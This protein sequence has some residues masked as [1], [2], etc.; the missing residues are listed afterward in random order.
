MANTLYKGDLAEVSFGKE[1]G[2]RIDG[3]TSQ[4]NWVHTS[5]SGNTSLLTLGADEYWTA[6]GP[7]LKLPDNIL[8][9][10]TLR[11]EGGDAY[12]A[13]DFATTKRTYY[14]TAS[15]TGAG[16]ITV[17]PALLTA[18][19]T[20]TKDDDNLVIDFYRCPTFESTM[21]T[22]NQQVKTD[23]FIGLLNE[24]AIPE[25]EIDVRQQHIVGLGR[26]VNILTS[27]RETL[28]GGSMQLNA[29][30]LR[31]MKYALGGHSAKSQ[32]EFA[33]SSAAGTAIGGFPLNIA[34]GS[35]TATL[36]AQGYGVS[37]NT[38][39]SITATNSSALTM[40]GNSLTGNFLLGGMVT[41][42]TSTDITFDTA[43][44]TTFENALTTGGIFKVL[45]ATGAVLYGS[46][47]SA[48]GAVLS[49]C[50]DIDSGALARAQTED[51]AVYLL[52]SVT[53]NISAGDIRIKVGSA[54]A[55]K[56]TAGTS[57][58]QII[59]KDKH[60]IPGQDAA[61]TDRQIFKNELRRVIAIGT[62]NGN[63]ADYIYVE[64][65]LTFDHT[66]TSCGVERL[67]Y[68]GTSNQRG[69]P[70]IDATSKELQFG[71]THTLFGHNVLPSFTV[72]QS[73][74]QKDADVDSKQLL[75]LY[76][77]C[78][79]TEATIDADSE[80]EVKLNLSYEAARHY[81][82][83]TNTMKPH[84]MFDNTAESA[85][86][87]KISGIAVD[88]EKPYL[89]QDVN[90]EVFGRP[91]LRG[92]QFSLSVTNNLES[93]WFIRGYEGTTVDND[94]IQHGATQLPLE[95]TEGKR[96]YSFS[97][98]VM[99]EDERLWD[100]LR[101]RKHH[102]NTNDI[103]ITMTKVGSNATRETATITLED[104]TITK[105]EHQVPSDKSPVMADVE[106][107]VR[108]M[109]VSENS[110]YFIL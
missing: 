33:Y 35:V 110:P 102:K 52:G 14:I 85:V 3:K 40:T 34:T 23:Q 39:T 5:V 50:A 87:R 77:G 10:C 42:D 32:G 59:D 64:E 75:R 46:Y 36:A 61:E 79:A 99:V 58:V 51:K 15:D 53:A 1:T 101:T 45:S 47:G 2:L 86:N 90:V 25:P 80:G 65:P 108:H 63:D 98:Q 84:R 37:D 18:S 72:E 62:S 107:V 69:S 6:T 83:T 28:S 95:I 96:E 68:T 11:I 41:A 27:G 94:Q 49:S 82:A 21:T 29:H 57:Y 91:V 26:D 103:T 104:Y 66:S 44:A 19:G 106:I 17:Q 70:H 8:I 4:A 20:A 24:F 88:G 100:E 67:Q 81:T 76:S 38:D 48:S 54:N 12:S 30:T 9:G 71:V 92:T 89:F 56:F 74:R 31:W 7:D 78:K 109:K 93:R 97:M 43:I 55:A 73:F 16:T 13:D 60:T 22:S 105:S